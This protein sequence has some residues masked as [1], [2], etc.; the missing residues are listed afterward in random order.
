MTIPL[1]LDHEVSKLAVDGTPSK[2][3]GETLDIL[4]TSAYAIKEEPSEPAS[5]ET[6]LTSNHG[7]RAEIDLI[8]SLRVKGRTLCEIAEQIKRS[9]STVFERLKIVPVAHL[10]NRCKSS[11]ISNKIDAETDLAIQLRLEKKTYKEIA[12]ELNLSI[13]TV[14]NRLKV[15]LTTGH[16]DKRALTSRSQRKRVLQAEIVKLI[17][18][19]Y[20]YKE[21]GDM[22]GVTRQ[23][24]YVLVKNYNEERKLENASLPSIKFGT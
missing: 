12:Q 23:R 6:N 13:A 2:E 21:V 15:A 11:R 10:P 1:H 8:I 16:L 14:A 18:A 7:L 3:L 4:L 17:I 20:K 22:L 24:I 19:G 9:P 5:F